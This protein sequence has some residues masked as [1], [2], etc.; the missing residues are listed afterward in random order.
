MDLHT[1]ATA[2]KDESRLTPSE[3][4]RTATVEKYTNWRLDFLSDLSQSEP[5]Q[6][7]PPERLEQTLWGIRFRAP[8]LNAAGL[9]KKGECY[10]T[11]YLQGAGAYLSGSTTW[12]PRKGNVKNGINSP[13]TP[14]LNSGTAS[15][16]MGM[17][18]EGDAVVAERLQRLVRE[19]GFPIGASV[20]PSPDLSG[21]EQVER[22]IDGLALYE[23][24]GVDFFEIPAS[25]PNATETSSP[26]EAMYGFLQKV[27]QGFL[28]SRVEKYTPVVVKFSTDTKPEQ[29]GGIVDMLLELG[30]D[31]VNFGNSSKNYELHA[32][33]IA[34]ADKELFKHFVDTFGGAL[35]GRVLKKSSLALVQAASKHL[36]SCT[37]EREFHIIRTG[38]VEGAA[39]VTAS[40]AAGASLVQWHTA[41]Y[42]Q[43]A[44]H[45]H[46]LYDTIW[47]AL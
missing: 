18:G 39:D 17:P 25:S 2:A 34:G 33:E 40:L 42:E 16:W 23:A 5:P 8:L 13:W 30:F 24:S 44:R 47:K 4:D 36:K 14:Y 35:T 38:G 43:Y 26:E 3:L 9:L 19:D 11:M 15:N 21:D 27:Q 32:T 12:N 41:Y 46:A 1:I 29:V 7:V 20:S 10:R 28:D 31:G 37:P 45:G 22:L 6:V